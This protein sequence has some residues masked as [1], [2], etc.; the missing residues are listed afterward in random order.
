V[1]GIAIAI[2]S[3]LGRGGNTGVAREHSS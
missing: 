2:Q 1:M 3:M